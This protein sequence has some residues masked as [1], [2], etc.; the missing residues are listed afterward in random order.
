VAARAI[1]LLLAAALIGCVACGDPHGGRQAVSGS[2][3]FQGKP[4]D[5]GTIT[6]LPASPDLPTQSGAAITGGKYSIPR[7]KGLVPG[8]YKVAINSPDGRPPD[9]GDA[10]PG[11]SGN[12][13]SKDRIPPAYNLDSKEEVVVKK[14]GPNA[15]DYKIP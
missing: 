15:F 13:A 11:P 9:G 2:V 5:R 6:F 8:K 14:G 12:F 4:L 3:T 7:D 10:P 1:R